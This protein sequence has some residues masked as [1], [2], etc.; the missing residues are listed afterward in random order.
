MRRIGKGSGEVVVPLLYNFPHEM[1]GGGVRARIE[2]ANSDPRPGCWGGG[3]TAN[4]CGRDGREAKREVTGVYEMPTYPP[5]D[6][7]CPARGSM[8]HGTVASAQPSL[9]LSALQSLPLTMPGRMQS[10]LDSNQTSFQVIDVAYCGV[11]WAYCNSIFNFMFPPNS[12][13]MQ[14]RIR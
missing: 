1:P 5:A 2:I 9:M 10:R 3:P 7:R 8:V 14:L 11:L 6:D 13:C 12:T 4:W